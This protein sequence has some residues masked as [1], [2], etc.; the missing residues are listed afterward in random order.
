MSVLAPPA[1]V[2]SWPAVVLRPAPESR[3]PAYRW[4]EPVDRRSAPD[5][6][7]PPGPSLF[8][9]PELTSTVVTDPVQLAAHRIRLVELPGG[10]RPRKDLPDPVVWC[11][12]LAPGLVEVLQRRR[13]IGQL[14]RWLDDPVLGALTVSL[15]LRQRFGAPLPAAGQVHTIRVQ[16]PAPESVEASV[17]VRLPRRSA[18]LAFRLVAG[19]GARW[20]CTAVDLGD[21]TLLGSLPGDTPSS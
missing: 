21:A 19:P 20:L 11:R 5:G 12:T 10:V 15:R 9:L 1:Q 17:H 3:P 8:D 13:P 18:A 2:D 4:L 6:A 14:A 7:A 16:C